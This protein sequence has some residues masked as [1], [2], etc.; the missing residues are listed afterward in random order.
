M[1]NW[2][3]NQRLYDKQ[4]DII[5][6][7][8]DSFNTTSRYL[9]DVL[10]ITSIYFD[11]LVKFHFQNFNLIKPIPLIPKP[12]CAFLMI[13]F[14]PKFTINVTILI[15]LL[16]IFHFRMVMFLALHPMKF[17]FLNSSDLLEP[18]VMLLTSK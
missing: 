17:I 15:L 18:L 6:N 4:T 9:D 5:H 11:N 2:H 10:N 1:D 14:L 13:L 16:S 3:D 12:F 7:I 8:I